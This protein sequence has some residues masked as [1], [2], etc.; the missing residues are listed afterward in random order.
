MAFQ[1]F[2]DGIP[3]AEYKIKTWDT[4]TFE[5]YF[6]AV[7]FAY[8]WA[9]PYDLATI[10]KHVQSGLWTMEVGVEYD[11]GMGGSPVMMCIKEV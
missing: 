3:C 2:Q 6:E 7:V 11:L 8:H 4:D 9:Y 10:T 1:V 5:E